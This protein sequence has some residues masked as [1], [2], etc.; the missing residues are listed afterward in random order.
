MDQ[1]ER[2]NCFIVMPFGKN[3]DERRWFKAWYQEVIEPAVIGAGYASLLA[4]Q[5]E[6]PEAINDEIRSHLAKD[7][8]VVVDLGGVKSSDEPNPNVMYELGIRHAFDLPVVIMGWE[9]QEIPFDVS[10]QRLILSDRH[11]INFS[12]TRNKLKA[13]IRAAE[14]GKY[15]RPMQAIKKAS[16]L[17]TAS[18]NLSQDS[19]LRLLVDAVAG[20]REKVDYQSSR[21][22]QKSNTLKRVFMQTKAARKSY[23]EMYTRLGGQQKHWHAVVGAKLDDDFIK[24]ANL[25]GKEDWEKHFRKEIKK[26]SECQAPIVPNDNKLDLEMEVILQRLQQELPEQPW[27]KGTH[28]LV[29]GKL[30][31]SNTQYN[32][33]VK[34]LIERGIFKRQENGEIIDDVDVA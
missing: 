8:M 3:Q 15:Y 33:A 6:Q 2:K 27:L 29:R 30:G 32:K 9:D 22:R 11:P 17:D 31:L 23:Y 16:L 5:Q 20:L 14:E 19:V 26:F 34:I 13:F 21:V 12:D 18:Q 1:D 4:A 28:L 10:N 7:T 25:W 24:A